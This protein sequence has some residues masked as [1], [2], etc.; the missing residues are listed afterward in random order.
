MQGCGPLQ[1]QLHRKAL[2]KV[3]REKTREQSVRF[4]VDMDESLPEAVIGMVED[5]GDD[6]VE[7]TSF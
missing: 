7:T 1:R 2:Q 3:W 5:P 6:A 4:A